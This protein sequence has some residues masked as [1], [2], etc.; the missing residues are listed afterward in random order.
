MKKKEKSEIWES[1]LVSSI[2]PTGGT[3]EKFMERRWNQETFEM[4]LLKERIERYRRGNPVSSAGR[5]PGLER[6]SG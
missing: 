4:L 1:L 6:G 2:L 5:I 3:A